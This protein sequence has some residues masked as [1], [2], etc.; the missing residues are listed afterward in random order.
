M[1]PGTL[2]SLALS[3]HCITLTHSS[4]KT[5]IFLFAVWSPFF[6]TWIWGAWPSLLCGGQAFLR[7]WP[8]EEW[9]QV[10]LEV[11][12]PPLCQHNS[13][14]HVGNTWDCGCI[15]NFYIVCESFCW[16]NC[17]WDLIALLL[18][19]SKV[20]YGLE[21]GHHFH[22]EVHACFSD[23]LNIVE[24]YEHNCADIVKNYLKFEV[25]NYTKLPISIPVCLS[26]T[27]FPFS[28]QNFRWWFVFSQHKRNFHVCIPL[29]F[30]FL[31]CFPK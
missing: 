19:A 13:V 17:Q 9:A 6:L 1:L 30:I 31:S 8:T 20:N 11:P 3:L 14:T 5:Q 16:G 18:W 22:V 15:R 23:F 2:G 21:S 7:H 26:S 28:S 27:H 24:S 29:C 10:L 4:V 12:V 25:L